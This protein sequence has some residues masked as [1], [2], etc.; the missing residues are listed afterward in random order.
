MKNTNRAPKGT[1]TALNI[2]ALAGVASDNG[3]KAD[4]TFRNA[5]SAVDA[6]HIRRCLKAGLVEILDRTTL[7][8]T[9]AGVAAVLPEMRDQLIHAARP[10]TN[11]W[12]PTAKRAQEIENMKIAFANLGGKL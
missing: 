4:R 1:P 6:P 5:I 2:S 12:T 3:I 9:D 7:K 10:S 8:L 11:G